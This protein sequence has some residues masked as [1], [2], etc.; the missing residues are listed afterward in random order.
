MFC[1]FS[2]VEGMHERTVVRYT[3][4]VRTCPRLSVRAWKGLRRLDSPGWVVP[5]PPEHGS[6]ALIS[7]PL[8]VPGLLLVCVLGVPGGSQMSDSPHKPAACRC[9]LTRGDTLAGKTN[10]RV[11]AVVGG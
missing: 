5:G 7:F 1:L 11:R 2:F 4:Q 10:R 6:S 3:V 9:S 8:W